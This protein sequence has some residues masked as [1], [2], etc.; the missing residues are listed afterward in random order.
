MKVG[1]SNEVT[2][3]VRE[4]WRLIENAMCEPIEWV[5]EPVW[6][7]YNGSFTE[8][9]GDGIVDTFDVLLVMTERRMQVS[10]A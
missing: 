10:T 6:N 8:H 4:I 1:V 3:P 7:I 2:P 9:L 5:P